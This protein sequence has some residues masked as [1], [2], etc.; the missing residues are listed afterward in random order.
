M[1][2]GRENAVKRFFKEMNYYLKTSNRY[3]IY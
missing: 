3:N 2:I 1:N